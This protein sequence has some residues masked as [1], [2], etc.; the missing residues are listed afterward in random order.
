MVHES[1]I[2]VDAANVV[3]A[4]PDGWWRDRRAATTRLRDRLAHLTHTGLPDWPHP[5]PVRVVL[6]T[7]GRARGVASSDTVTVEEATGSGDDHIV[8]L[9]AAGTVPA[10]VVTS[11]RELR[12]RVHAAGG[13][14]T[15]A[16]A[17]RHPPPADGTECSRH[18]T[19]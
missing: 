8:D 14:T 11:D 3:G 2:I 16:A 15:G 18:D 17:L 19:R 9:V 13:H 5:P 12:R 10:L 7:E 1:V 4:T 6:V